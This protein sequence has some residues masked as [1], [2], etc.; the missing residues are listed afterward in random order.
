MDKLGDGVRLAYVSAHFRDLCTAPE[1]WKCVLGPAVRHNGL[2]LY[3]SA[4]LSLCAWLVYQRRQFSASSAAAGSSPTLAFY[5]CL[6]GYL[7]MMG[8]KA[9]T[10]GR[11][12]NRSGVISDSA[13]G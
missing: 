10:G 1:P 13:R 3:L 7:A 6:N 11:M 2:C 12:V 5:Q 9:G 4:A 8:L